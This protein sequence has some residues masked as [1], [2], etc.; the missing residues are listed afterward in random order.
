MSS[1]THSDPSSDIQRQPR[2][3]YAP[4]EYVSGGSQPSAT[5]IDGYP[6]SHGDTPDSDFSPLSE[7]DDMSMN[8]LT[9]E[10]QRDLWHMRLGHIFGR[11]IGNLHE[12]ADGIPKFQRPDELH[13]CPMCT[14]AKLHKALRNPTENL[15]CTTCWQD[16][17]VD[18]GFF[19]QQSS[20]RKTS[21]KT[22]P[23][24]TF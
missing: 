7:S 5:R 11:R 12:A 14:R 24:D 8:L 6:S 17:Q 19:V 16:I 3:N 2:P 20:G 4:Q 15:E 1:H 18:F 13:K 21:K 9:Y 23:D 10:Q 22:D